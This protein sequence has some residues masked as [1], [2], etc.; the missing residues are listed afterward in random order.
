MLG[1][2]GLVANVAKYL[3]GQPVIG[4]NP[5]P[6]W[7]E[8][9]LVRHP[10]EAAEDLLADVAAARA[11]IE[12]RTMV[13]AKL[14]AGPSLIALNEIFVGQPSHQSAR[15]RL[16]LDQRSE[17]QSSSGLIVS[18]GTGS[19]GWARSIHTERSADFD[20]PEPTAASLSWF[21]REAW[22]SLATGNELTSGLL[23][24]DQ[25]LSLVSEME[26]GVVFGDGVEADRLA[27]GWGQPVRVGL[28]DRTLRL[29]V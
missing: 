11:A 24:G 5:E 4:L 22:P 28:A 14:D 10:T 23:R 17:R 7:N 20:L 18:T 12:E 21:V 29:V 8:G 6:E 2:D 27:I 25:T 1:Q 15:Y 3:D 26:S 19:S 16:E 9:V 13:E